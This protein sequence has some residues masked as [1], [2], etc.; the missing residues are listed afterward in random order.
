MC[1]HQPPAV[2]VS[3]V[4]T[5]YTVQSTL[6]CNSQNLRTLV[7]SPDSHITTPCVRTGAVEVLK[8]WL[9]GGWGGYIGG[10]F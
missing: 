7:N 5:H 1:C 8:G 3:D 2:R 6:C 9:E 4:G 10:I